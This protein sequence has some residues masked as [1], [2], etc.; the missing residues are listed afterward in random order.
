[1]VWSRLWGV[2]IAQ[3]GVLR[4]NLDNLPAAPL[5]AWLGDYSYGEPD[6]IEQP[7]L[8]PKGHTLH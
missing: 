5:G 2:T 7:K 3:D 1:V 8:Q 6:F 4:E